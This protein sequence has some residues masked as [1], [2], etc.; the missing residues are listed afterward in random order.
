MTSGKGAG[1]GLPTTAYAILGPVT[2]GEIS[3]YDL[4]RMAD[5]SIRYFF[6]SPASSQIY[7]ELRRLASLGYVTERGVAQDRRPDKRLYRITPEGEQALTEWLERPEVEADVI[8]STFLLKL[9][10]GKFTSPETLVAQIRT[11]KRQAEETLAQ[12]EEIERRIE[13]DA[14]FFFPCLTLKSGILHSRARRDWVEDA[15]EDLEGSP[16]TS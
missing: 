4:K 7:S 11:R 16:K 5:Q 13:G 9:F 10:F 12:L 15:L 2:F 1:P 8:K 6:W 3:G 14:R